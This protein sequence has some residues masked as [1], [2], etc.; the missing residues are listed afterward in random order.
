MVEFLTH[1]NT[2]LNHHAVTFIY[3]GKDCSMSVHW[4]SSKRLVV[5]RR[6]KKKSP[7]ARKRYRRKRRR[8]DNNNNDAGNYESRRVNTIDADWT[9]R[10]QQSGE[11]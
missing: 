9:S 4:D 1:K 2:T 11:N 8:Q 5:T 7:E 3:L 10:E 6:K